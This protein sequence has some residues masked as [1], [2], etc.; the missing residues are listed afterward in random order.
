[1]SVDENLEKGNKQ[2]DKGKFDQAIDYYK[3]IL[4]IEPENKDALIK[5]GLSFRQKEEYDTAIQWYDKV[6]DIDAED[7]IAINNIG[8]ALECKA[9]GA[10]DSELKNSLMD[11]AIAKYERSLEIDPSYE[12]PLVNLTNI[13]NDREE[14]D[15]TIEYFVKALKE[16]PLNVANWIDLGRAYRFK[17]M[18]DKSIEAYLTALKLDPD[19]KIAWNN[20][21]WVYYCK[22]DYDFA[23]DAYTR[24]MKIDWKYDLPFANIIKIYKKMVKSGSQDYIAWRNLSYGF[25][26]G[27][28]YRRAL[29]SNNRS[30]AIKPDFKEAVELQEDIFK[31]KRKVDLLQNLEQAIDEALRLFSITAYAVLLRDVIKYIKHNNPDLVFDSVEIKFKILEFIR[32]KGVPAKLD[33]NKIIFIHGEGQ[34]KSDISI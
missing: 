23:I 28:A 14:Y 34:P 29:D 5:I 22:K 2:Y 1:M 3:R 8:Y 7:K 16:D 15:K 17:E 21:G 33:V 26:V 25:L 27:K 10:E 4:D 24:S 12:I 19:D 20:I 31:Q 13:F 9:N 6:L 30:L 11:Q 18:Y 32:D